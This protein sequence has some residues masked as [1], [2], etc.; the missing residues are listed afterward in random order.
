[1]IS[2]GSRGRAIEV[3]IRTKIV[4]LLGNKK[5][6]VPPKGA[7]PGYQAHHGGRCFIVPFPVGR[8]AVRRRG[9]GGMRRLCRRSRCWC[10]SARSPSRA[11]RR[12]DHCEGRPRSGPEICHLPGITVP[13]RR[14]GPRKRT[15][16]RTGDHD[17]RIRPETG[18]RRRSKVNGRP[19]RIEPPDVTYLRAEA[20]AEGRR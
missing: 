4:V 7:D 20:V 12:P 2:A 10:E 11:A 17:V 8:H 13:G 9:R 18:W 6:Q 1:M 5:P 16:R 14:P 19:T 15:T 3:L